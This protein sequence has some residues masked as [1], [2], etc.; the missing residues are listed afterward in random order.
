M[1][2]VSRFEAA[3]CGTAELHGL[4][5]EALIAFSAAARGS[6][7]RREVLESIRNIENELATRAPG[8]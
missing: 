6:Q 4:L 2:L 5:R 7:E 1:K 8:L 3:S